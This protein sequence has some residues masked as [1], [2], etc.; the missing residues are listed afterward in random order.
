LTAHTILIADDHP[1]FR[2]ALRLAIM[3][4]SPG[5]K[6]LEA[7][8]L[9]EASAYMRGDGPLDLVLLDLK[10]SDS[11]GFTGLAQLHAERPKAPI[12]VVSGADPGKAARGAKEYGA[13]GFISKSAGLSEIAKD[14]AD[15][16]HGRTLWRD[17]HADMIDPE[18]DDMA[19]RVASLTPA[20]LKVL[21]GILHGRLNKQ[22][23]Y[24]LDIS[25]ATVK[26]HVTVLMRKLNVRSRTQAALA[27]RALALD[28]EAVA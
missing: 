19:K 1:L 24:E 22:I 28:V 21:I 17:T 16:L 15:V 9:S 14:V 6:I 5:A 8:S 27:A 20:Q 18:T 2:D 4:A 26:A 11:Q 23:A 10:M 7:S 12:V 3:R 13:V 25:E